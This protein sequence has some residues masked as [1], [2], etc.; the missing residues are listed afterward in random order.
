MSSRINR[1]IHRP[2]HQSIGPSAGPQ[3]STPGGTASRP[4]TT[5]RVTTATMSSASSR[6]SRAART[7]GVGESW[8]EELIWCEPRAATFARDLCSAGRARLHEATLQSSRADSLSE[9]LCILPKPPH[10]ASLS[11]A[12]RVGQLRS[13]RQRLPVRPSL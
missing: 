4:V 13:E 6:C 3:A 12:G 11:P 10:L 2:L 7:L 5:G 8:R 1:S 9:A